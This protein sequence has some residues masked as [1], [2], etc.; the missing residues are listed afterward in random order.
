ML[1]R[2]NPFQVVGIEELGFIWMAEIL[3]SGYPEEYRYHMASRIVEMLGKHFFPQPPVIPPS[4]VKPVWIPPLLDFLS[5]CEKLHVEVFPP[6]PG[7]IALRMLSTIQYPCGF[8][9]AILPVLASTLLPTNPLESRNLALKVFHT[10]MSEWFSPQ[11]ENILNRD[12]NKLLRAV[13]DPFQHLDLPLQDG[14]P[15]D[16]GDD[17]SLRVTVILM[18]FA[19]S[20]LWGNH[21]CYSNFASCEWIVSTD[22]GRI[23][24]LKCMLRIATFSLPDFLD[25]PTKIIAAI[26]RLEELQCFS[27]AE[28]I[29]M[30]AWTIG[31]I[32]P[33]NRVAWKSIQDETLRFYQNH[34]F[35][36]LV[37]LARIIDTIIGSHHECYLEGRYVNS[38]CRVWSLRLLPRTSGGRMAW[39]GEWS[40]DLRVSQACQLRGLYHLFGYDPTT[41]R[42]A[43]AVEEAS[44]G[45]KALSKCSVASASSAD[46]EY[47][48]P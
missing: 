8:A 45:T 23:A 9:A 37:A 12:L 34:R 29:I 14:Q 21:L 47:N 42:E 15:A 10:F 46:W 16:T 26:R 39:D 22:E 2:L 4:H 35:R 28:I 25:T 1:A 20:D 5:L 43:V 7:P 19:S 33:E 40:V 24:V 11:I 3:S 30:W 44:E 18:E 48:Y 17:D 31:I 27:T 36:C 38:P 13:G 32:D 6:Y 41:W